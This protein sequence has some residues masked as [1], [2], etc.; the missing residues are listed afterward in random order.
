MNKLQ[1]LAASAAVVLAFGAQAKLPP[2][3]PEAKAKAEEAKA[4]AAWTDKVGSF[5]LCQSMDRTAAHYY[6][7]SGKDAKAA[8]TTAPCADPGPFVYTPPEAAP[9]AA[10][11]AAAA[12]PIEAA[13]AHSPAKTAVAP[14]NDKATAAE[15]S[16]TAPKK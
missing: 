16:G 11:P 14:P 6:K 10:T 3:S 1:L 2:L 4:K 8:T 9:A 5:K 12:P 13:G 15:K 7:T